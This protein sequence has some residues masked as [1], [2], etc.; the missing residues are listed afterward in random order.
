[1]ASGFF[2]F[3]RRVA[4]RLAL[5]LPPLARFVTERNS[6]VAERN[7]LV[8]ERDSLV[9]ER[10]RVTTECIALRGGNRALWEQARNAGLELEDMRMRFERLKD[11]SRRLHTEQAFFPLKTS[12]CIVPASMPAS[13]IAERL[14]ANYVCQVQSAFEP[15]KSRKLRL[16]AEKKMTSSRGNPY[17]VVFSDVVDAANGTLEIDV[18]VILH[19]LSSPCFDIARQYFQ[20]KCG[21][22][23]AVIILPNLL[24]RRFDP[25]QAA[26]VLDET[27]IPYHQD[28]FGFPVGFEVLNVW[29]LLSPDECGS[30]SPGLEFILDRFGKFIDKEG[31]PTSQT[32]QFLETSHAAID[33]YLQVYDPWRPSVALGDALIFTELALHRTYLN[34]TQKAARCSAEVRLI[35]RSQQ[36]IDHL[37]NFPEPHYTIIGDVLSGPWRI[38]SDS[39]GRID[40][41]EVSQWEIVRDSRAATAELDC[42]P[43]W[44]CRASGTVRSKS[45]NLHVDQQSVAKQRNVRIH[46]AVRP[47][48]RTGR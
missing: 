5:L 29:T 16:L 31:N 3:P 25:A 15:T 8:A 2:G 44:R 14:A 26:A 22:T 30:T 47:L 40:V 42:K 27:K 37:T 36:V 10:D 20:K 23:D 39:S 46:A 33:E 41:L 6:R 48:H 34:S 17:A 11:E 13:K 38:R 9:A 28:A 35:G 32:Y 43:H 1:M 45:Q 24:V 19:V 18:S 21:T 7:S 4:K 12:S